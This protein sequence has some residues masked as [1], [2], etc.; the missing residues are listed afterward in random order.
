MDKQKIFL[1]RDTAAATD[2]FAFLVE[3]ESGLEICGEASNLPEY[4]AA[5]KNTSPDVILLEASFGEEIQTPQLMRSIKTFAPNI[6]ILI[7]S[8]QDENI[9]AEVALRAGARGYVMKHEPAE[10]ILEAIRRVLSGDIYLSQKLA[11]QMLQEFVKTKRVERENFG[12]ESLSDRE[13]EIFELIGRGLSTRKIADR[14]KLSIK[15]IETHRAHIKQKL[16]LV[17][18]S[19]L[20]YRAFHWANST[21]AG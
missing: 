20:A 7:L 3:N 14:L 6:P 2:V 12:V 17:D 15:T 4:L 5:S 8:D 16:K 18:S 10:I 13:L 19:G 21:S 1:I 9:Y 11:S